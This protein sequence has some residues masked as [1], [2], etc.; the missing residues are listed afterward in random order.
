M[1]EME[2]WFERKFKLD[3]PVS[4]FPN[5][6]ERLR[7]VPVRLEEHLLPLPPE[8]LIFKRGKD[9]SVQEHAGHLLDLES[10]NLGRL[11]DYEQR[12]TD[13]RPAD[14]QN[15][16]TYEANHNQRSIHSLLSEFRRE[17]G[18]F[19]RRLQNSDAEFVSRN[20]IHPR[21]QISMRVIDLA[22]FIAEHDDHHLTT[23]AASIRRLTGS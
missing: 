1:V 5:V 6:V 23:I 22:Y 4:L 7:G 15:R 18:L 14:L 8:L 13:L 21:L 16:K 19:V 10:L 3:L 2:R 12:L 11:D 20:A 9:W 17:R